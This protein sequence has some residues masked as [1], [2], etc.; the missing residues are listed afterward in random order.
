MFTREE[1][2]SRWA[3]TCAA[4]VAKGNPLPK[5]RLGLATLIA[6][7]FLLLQKTLDGRD[8]IDHP[9]EV[10][11]ANTDSETQKIVGMLHDV[12]E[13]SPFTLEDLREVGFSE[14]IVN[15]VDGVTKR[16]GELY[17]DFIER[18]GTHGKYAIDTKIKDLTHNSL[19]IRNFK[20]KKTD[21]Q[22]W[23]EKAYNVSYYYLVAIKKGKIAPATKIDFFI[24]EAGLHRDEK[25]II[26]ECLRKFS[27]RYQ[28][29][30]NKKL[31]ES[32]AK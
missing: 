16:P 23:K 29:N 10:S 15:A 21:K 6:S 14:V 5:A 8:Y 17:F 9:T 20:V 30:D 26:D 7:N 12:V 1:M 3:E 28:A 24:K 4:E 32:F 27:M 13:D 19:S 2:K 22:I 11:R 31:K 25:E 18:C